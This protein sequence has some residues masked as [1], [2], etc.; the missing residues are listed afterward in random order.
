MEPRPS[1]APSRDRLASG[2]LLVAAPLLAIGIW[3]AL[4]RGSRTTDRDL[5]APLL[6]RQPALAGRLAGDL[7]EAAH[8]S[9]PPIFGRSSPATPTV[10]GSRQIERRAAIDPG[11]ASLY[12]LGL[13]RLAEGRLNEAILTLE[14]VAAVSAADAGPANDLAVAYLTRA[15]AQDRAFDLVLSIEAAERALM[16]DPRFPQALYNRALALT[17]LHLEGQARS[18][19]EAFLQVEPRAPA[20]VEAKRLLEELSQRTLEEQWQ[21]ESPRLE[22]I[23]L[24]RDATAL[25]S[26]VGGF[27]SQVRQDAEERLLPAW[28]SVWES[29]DLG[30]ASAGLGAVRQIGLALWE[31]THDAMVRDAVAV[32]DLAEAKRDRGRLAALA[33]GQIAYGRGLALYRHQ[34]LDAAVPLV[35]SARR[36]LTAAGSPLAN[37]A[38]L[39][40]DI[41]LH[42]RNTS[43]AGRQLAELRGRTDEHLYPVLAGQIEWMLGTV[44]NNE[45]RPEAALRHFHST[46]ELLEPALG[47]VACGFVHVLLAETFQRLGEDQEAWRQRRSALGGTARLGDRRRLHG[48]LY[49]AAHS[50]VEEG[51]PALALD[52]LAEL[53]ESDLAWARA[54]A[55]AE[56]HLLHGQALELLGRGAEALAA[57]QA[58]EAQ[59]AAIGAGPLRDRVAAEISLAEGEGLVARDPRRAVESLT[60]TLESQ[61]GEGYRFQVIR[62]L[63]ARARAYRALG[64][65]GRVKTDLERAIAEHERVRGSVRD[66]Q[67]RLSYFERAQ[68]AFDE[69]VSFELDRGGEG[70]EAFDY[71][72]RARSRLLLDL[73]AGEA[74]GGSL[75]RALSGDAVRARLPRSVGLIEYAVLRDQV[76]AWMAVAGGEPLHAVRL[77]NDPAI[78]ARQVRALRNA[79]E[80]RA[81]E[82]EIHDAA[83]A[84]FDVLVRPLVDRLP[85]NAAVVFVPDRFLS[86][87][88]FA[89]LLDARSG[90]YLIEDRLV[91]VA[92]SATLYVAAVEG[93]S[94]FRRSARWSTLAVGDPAFDTARYPGLPRL[95]EA[96]AEAREA[97]A[98]DPGSELLEGA[99]ATRDAVLAGAGRHRVLHFA[100]HALLD[101]SQP[102]GS[103]LALAPGERADDGALYASDVAGLHL[104]GTELVVLS[105]C[106]TAADVAGG[107]EVLTG[108]AAAFLAAGPR[109]VVAS[110]WDVDD[111]ATR[112]LMRAFDLALPKEGEPASALRAAQL[113]LLHGGPP[114][115]RSPASWAGFEAFGGSLPSTDVHREED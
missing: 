22:S 38:E 90:R 23:A 21:Q 105:A 110:L 98:L 111:R 20:S 8:T 71:A 82:R 66:E 24:R 100:G 17:Q 96:A 65:E 108:L 44:E 81:G 112:E 35:S 4:G 83:A 93:G 86:Q 19:W 97:A 95:P 53:L 70:E 32:I 18:A 10:R 27:A 34:E 62:V 89:A 46:L 43:E 54:G 106:R 99:A 79:L 1:P 85:T 52:I 77:S 28:G 114:E 113:Q 3:M 29:G 2:L 56:T 73:T 25:R 12:D 5:L 45:G 39:Y 94:R 88:P 103:H 47:K 76:V 36:A 67:L 101:A 92:P 40:A 102:T 63:T 60:K 55:L 13:L 14:A 58:A 115:L 59:S 64:D 104:E 87:V 37:E 7:Q 16:V 49:E 15:E 78:T 48:A 74:G 72:E 50:L 42:Y 11:K 75:P 6:A 9:V 41:C 33:A 57:F 51:A 61:L 91:A 109:V 107:R 80:R 69:M 26:V 84:L 30:R 31:T 68:A